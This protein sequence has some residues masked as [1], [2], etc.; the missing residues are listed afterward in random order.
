[1]LCIQPQQLVDM[2]SCS[3]TLLVPYTLAPGTTHFINLGAIYG[4]Y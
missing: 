1:M 3:I 4:K 2:G